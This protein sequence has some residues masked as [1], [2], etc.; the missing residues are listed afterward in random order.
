MDS[1]QPLTASA[2]DPRYPIGNFSWDGTPGPDRTSLAAIAEL[3]ARLAEALSGLEAAQLDTPY[4]EGG[5]TLR[6]LAHHVA[7]SHINAYTRL[8]LALT[9][10]WPV[11]KPYREARWAEL[12]DACT[13]PVEAS[14]AL[15]VPLH[16]RWS[17]LLESL[18]SA[19]WTDRGYTHPENGRVSLAQ[20]GALYSWHGR[21]HT[22]QVLALRERM[23][24]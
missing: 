9:E 21:H 15:L 20:M 13:L 1:A 2:P 19:D 18:S 10:E 8:R 6:Q 23:G 5:W 16:A 14:L 17:S 12:W 3:P 4:R 11:I 24:W 22:A 7:D